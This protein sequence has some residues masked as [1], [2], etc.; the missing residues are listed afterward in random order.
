VWHQSSGLKYL[1]DYSPAQA[2]A[3]MT[4][5]SYLKFVVVRNPI[6]VRSYTLQFSSRTNAH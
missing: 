1:T 4:D 5:P 2:Q 3:L 6:K